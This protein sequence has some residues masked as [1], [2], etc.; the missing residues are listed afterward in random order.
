M[1]IAERE[2]PGQG[3]R[4]A[5]RVGQSSPAARSSSARNRRPCRACA[6]FVFSLIQSRKLNSVNP[7]A[8]LADLTARVGDHPASRFDALLLWNRSAR[9]LE[10]A[11]MSKS[12]AR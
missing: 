11:P 2:R 9:A 1:A 7:V 4:R 5:R 3:R 8:D 10:I 12:A 6:A